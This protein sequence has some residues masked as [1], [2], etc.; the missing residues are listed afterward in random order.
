MRLCA[1]HPCLHVRVPRAQLYATHHSLHVGQV[2]LLVINNFR[3]GN[4]IIIA[5]GILYTYSASFT[6]HRLCMK[7]ATSIRPDYAN[8]NSTC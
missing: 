5:T 2:H 3:V 7:K 8:N 1:T 6:C 4:H